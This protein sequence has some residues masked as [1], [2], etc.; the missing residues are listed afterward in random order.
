MKELPFLVKRVMLENRAP[1]RISAWP[2]V[3][4]LNWTRPRRSTPPSSRATSSLSSSAP[5]TA[6]PWHQL[7]VA[8][9][10]AWASGLQ[11]GVVVEVFVDFFK[12]QVTIP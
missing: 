10:T 6:T 8:T 5:S 9:M 11:R 2:L 3:A 12:G 4:G 1:F 7:F